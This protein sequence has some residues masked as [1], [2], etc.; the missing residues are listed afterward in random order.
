MSYKIIEIVSYNPEWPHWFELVK[1]QLSESIGDLVLSI[2]HIGST[3]V[4]GLGAKNRI[5]IQVTVDEISLKTKEFI[6]RGL[7]TIDFGEIQVSRD[8]RPNF[9]THSEDHWHCTQGKAIP[10]AGYPQLTSIFCD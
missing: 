1:L 6:D 8:H 4:P 7:K 2:D 10:I 3:A 5:D 9:D